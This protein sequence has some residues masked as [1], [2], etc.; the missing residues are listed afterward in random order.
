MLTVQYIM[1][2]NLQELSRKIADHLKS[3]SS[4]VVVTHQDADG[5]AAG[6]IARAAL[7]R[8]GITVNLTVIKQLDRNFIE[9]LNTSKDQLYWFTDLGSGNLDLLSDLDVV[10]TDHHEVQADT[11]D[12][13]SEA[14]MDLMQLSKMIDENEMAAQVKKMTK[15]YHEKLL[16]INLWAQHTP[17]GLSKRVKHWVQPP[18]RVYPVN[19]E[20]L[21]LNE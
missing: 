8:E 14:R 17:Y 10:I 1:V 9:G 15:L 19:I 4:V 2:S 3:R 21:T 18:G 12:L 6:S 13:P 20:Y 11:V 7:E 5:L 16:R